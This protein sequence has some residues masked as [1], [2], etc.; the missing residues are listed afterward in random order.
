MN[1]AA[2]PFPTDKII[3]CFSHFSLKEGSPP[4]LTTS[5][6]QRLATAKPVA[7]RL[8]PQ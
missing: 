7:S 3:L 1:L 6:I 5:R 4:Y 2:I 8:F